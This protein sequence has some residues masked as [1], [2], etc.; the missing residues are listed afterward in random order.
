M[1]TAL[2][3]LVVMAG[4]RGGAFMPAPWMMGRGMLGS[5]FPARLEW[6][7]GMGLHSIVFFGLVLVG[8]LLLAR[9]HSGAR[10]RVVQETPLEILKRRY[11]SGEATREQYE[12][13]RQDL[14][15]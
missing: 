13:V 12:Q 8:G 15:R 7:P 4:L 5:G 6:G 3:L 2:G 14:E 10:S 9:L 11:A 1:T